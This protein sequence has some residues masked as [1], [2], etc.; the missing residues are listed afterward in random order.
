MHPVGDVAFR[1]VS[2]SLAQYLRKEIPA[3][4]RRSGHAVLGAAVN[5]TIHQDAFVVMKILAR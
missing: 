1:W 3:R 4:V 5:A 2:A